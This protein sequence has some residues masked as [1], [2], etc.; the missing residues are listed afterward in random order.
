M[1]MDVLWSHLIRSFPCYNIFVDYLEHFRYAIR[2]WI[3]V[4][5]EIRIVQNGIGVILYFT[6]IERNV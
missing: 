5:D 3:S 6:Q 4:F 2:I 1:Q